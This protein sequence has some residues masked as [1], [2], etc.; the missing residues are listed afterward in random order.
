ML[1]ALFTAY[2]QNVINHGVQNKNCYRGFFSEKQNQ[3]FVDLNVKINLYFDKNI[4]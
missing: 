1:A 4:I 2:I 3:Q